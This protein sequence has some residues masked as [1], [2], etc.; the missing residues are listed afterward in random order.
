MSFCMSGM[1][2]ELGTNGNHLRRSHVYRMALVV[3]HDEATRPIDIGIHPFG[4]N[5]DAHE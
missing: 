3:K 2:T 5:S 1:T 4:W